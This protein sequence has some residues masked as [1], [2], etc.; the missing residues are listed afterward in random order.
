MLTGY[1]MVCGDFGL[2]GGVYL[3]GMV[4]GETLDKTCFKWV[5]L[6][7]GGGLE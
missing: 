3:W 7:V 4:G 5:K 2:N 6:G 1:C